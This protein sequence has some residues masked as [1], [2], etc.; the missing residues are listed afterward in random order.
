MAVRWWW[1]LVRFG[2]RLLYNEMAFTYDTVSRLVSLGQWRG[3]QRSA[4]QMLP[5]QARDGVVLEL[6]HGTG[7]LQLDLKSA[8]YRTIGF[9]LSAQMGRI[10]RRK[11]IQ[12]GWEPRLVRGMAQSLPFADAQFPAIVCTFPSPFIFEQATLD[13]LA[14]VLHP[15]GRLVIVLSGVFTGRGPVRGVLE[16][17]YRITGQRGDTVHDVGARLRQLFVSSPFTIQVVHIPCHKSEAVLILAE[18]GAGKL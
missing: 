8:G 14:R 16:L 5:P 9:D 11:L 13:E 15:A 1:R 10:A 3:W 17:L 4:L 6:A 12:H 7:D 2:F 18:K